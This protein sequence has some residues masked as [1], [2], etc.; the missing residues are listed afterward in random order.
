MEPNPLYRFRNLNATCTFSIA[1]DAYP[2]TYG[3]WGPLEFRVER[4]PIS[5][6]MLEP[7]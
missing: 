7:Q 6:A 4:W 2:V 1:K 3:L 5:W